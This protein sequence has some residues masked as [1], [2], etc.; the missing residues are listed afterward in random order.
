MAENIKEKI[1]LWTG[2][3][4]FLLT[5]AGYGVYYG[6]LSQRVDNLESRTSKIE[7]IVEDKLDVLTK[8][9]NQ[10]TVNIA[11]LTEKVEQLRTH[12]K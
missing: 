11:V 7:S 4:I 6:K 9:I 3:I 8:M 2:I 12:N 5:I 10:Q 1:T